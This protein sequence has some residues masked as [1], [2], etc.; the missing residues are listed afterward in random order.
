[1]TNT[2]YVREN[3]QGGWD[4]LAEGHRRASVQADT[5]AKAVAQAR[6]VVRRAGGGE[7]RV[8]NRAGK[9]VT[10]DTVAVPRR[11]TSRAR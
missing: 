5:K 7:V 1:M 6:E 10:A 4:V 2:R 11:R 8:M 9:I 3:E